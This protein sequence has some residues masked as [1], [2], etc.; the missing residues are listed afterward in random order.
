VGLDQILDL[1][2]SSVTA[3]TV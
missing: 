3:I 2:S 1:I